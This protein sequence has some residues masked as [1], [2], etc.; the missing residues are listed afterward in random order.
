MFRRETNSPLTIMPQLP[1]S[2]LQRTFWCFI[3]YRHADNKEPGRQWATWLHQM[4]ETYEVPTDLVG[5]TNDRGDVI[6]ERIYPVFRDEEELPVDADLAS[7]I[8]RALDASKFLL[9]ICSPR[10]VA[11]NY[12]AQEISYFKQLGREDR[13][14]AAMIDG[15]PNASQDPKQSDQECFPEPLRHRVDAQGQLLKEVAEP[16]A[17]DFR[18]DDFSQGWCSPE[19]YR[20][21]LKNAGKWSHAQIEQRVS[22]YQQRCELMKLKIVAGVLG[23]PLGTLTQRDKAYQL[24]LSRKRAKRLRQWLAAVAV[25]GLFA[26]AGAVIATQQ[27]RI[28]RQQ[29]TRAEEQAAIARAQ[30]K[31][32]QEQT[33]V[34]EQQRAEAQ[35]QTVI[36]TENLGLAR[37]SLAET[38]YKEASRLIQ[39]PPGAILPAMESMMASLESDPGFGPSRRMMEHEMAT[40]EWVV[41]LVSY[42]DDSPILRA[43][44]DARGEK[45]VLITKDATL[46]RVDLH[47]GSVMSSAHLATRLP[48]GTDIISAACDPSQQCVA[49]LCQ[50]AKPRQFPGDGDDKVWNWSWQLYVFALDGSLI[51]SDA[52][53]AVNLNRSF[54]A[55]ADQRSD[56]LADQPLFFASS[57]LL[58]LMGTND[59]MAWSTDASAKQ[60]RYLGAQGLALPGKGDAQERISGWEY[61]L[62]DNSLRYLTN[63]QII[64]QGI[65]DAKLLQRHVFAQEPEELFPSPN[66]FS[67][68]I[69]FGK[70]NQA[71]ISG[72]VDVSFQMPEGI[73]VGLPK[74]IMAAKEQYSNTF[75]SYDGVFQFTRSGGWMSFHKEVFDYS[76]T[77]ADGAMQGKFQVSFPSNERATEWPPFLMR[78]G[79]D[80]VLLLS[81]VQSGNM[82][83]QL[84][85]IIRKPDLS[86]EEWEIP[87][88]RG[89]SQIMNGETCWIAA[90][91]TQLAQIHGGELTVYRIGWRAKTQP[92]TPSSAAVMPLSFCAQDLGDDD[93]P[94]A[95]P[96]LS[97]DTSSSPAALQWE[98]KSFPLPESWDKSQAVAAYPMK[99]RKMQ[100]VVLERA[101]A[102]GDLAYQDPFERRF[103]LWVIDAER[104]TTFLT[105]ELFSFSVDAEESSLATCDGSRV[106]IFSLP[107]C[108]EIRQFLPKRLSNH[109]SAPAQTVFFSRD[110][111][112]LGVGSLSSY[113][114]VVM[115]YRA[116]DVETGTEYLIA[117]TGRTVWHFDLFLSQKHHQT[118]EWRDG[119][120]PRQ[121]MP[122]YVAGF[123]RD[124]VN[125]LQARRSQSVKEFRSEQDP[126]S[127]WSILRWPEFAP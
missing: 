107:L 40:R 94:V 121:K 3:S 71:A 10:A 6:P 27:A 52:L 12:V 48:K 93:K 77:L 36:A 89:I 29:T 105:D 68:M 56:R 100:L 103:R 33:I 106:R 99:T 35:K 26:I 91:G 13:V 41:P 79:K 60:F 111:H 117:R 42:R 85:E 123:G 31:I 11:S 65:T 34:A 114:D 46:R 116:F 83:P 72:L 80:S 96:Q 75:T 18:L 95:P 14:L 50:I 24:E 88:H 70:G 45:A 127:T 30:S 112:V 58:M 126:K 66:G 63:R 37:K 110:S 104:G 32:A 21:E 62:S 73:G 61:E 84:L 16:V 113:Q 2:P 64:Q 38:H 17:A 43:W 87:R 122:F 4:L 57:Q 125:S 19:A 8:F 92:V 44:L 82:E 124:F 59:I 76:P 120:A 98:G 119:A 49:L 22:T 23:I 15:I 1:A 55:S 9:V 102:I 54:Y 118:Q 67:G 81:I 101:K 97:W 74:E 86:R 28:A 47:N 108:E 7:P 78:D 90:D 53:A 5:T 69:S 39:G 25:L 20:Q 51:G 109:M 115:D